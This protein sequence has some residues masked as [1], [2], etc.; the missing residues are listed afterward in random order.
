MK[1]ATDVVGMILRS[2]V[3]GGNRKMDKSAHRGAKDEIDNDDNDHDN[4]E[5]LP[6]NNDDEEEDRI[7]DE[8]ENEI[9]NH[10][11]VGNATDE[12]KTKMIKKIVST[13]HHLLLL[14]MR[15]SEK[16][17]RKDKKNEGKKRGKEIKGD[18][19]KKK[20]NQNH[21]ENMNEQER[22]SGD[23]PTSRSKFPPLS[24]PLLK[25][26]SLTAWRVS[27]LLA[28]LNLPLFRS[29]EK[30]GESGCSKVE[31]D[32]N[33]QVHTSSMYVLE[34]NLTDVVVERKKVTGA[35]VQGYGISTDISQT[36]GTDNTK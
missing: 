7:H 11:D 17:K 15:K 19:K 25:R 33:V 21:L 14:K 16:D 2:P 12:G 29:D 23:V 5:K 27:P 22:E 31:E 13:V 4:D 10:A 3:K 1:L 18:H 28:P 35:H 32:P 20:T 24:L 34:G 36:P 9:K 8:D 26:I 30:K 6:D